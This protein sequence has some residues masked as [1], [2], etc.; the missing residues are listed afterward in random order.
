MRE[1]LTEL[2]KETVGLLEKANKDEFALTLFRLRNICTNCWHLGAYHKRKLNTD[3]CDYCGCGHYSPLF[4]T[5]KIK[6][7][8]FSGF[9]K[10]IDWPKT[11]GE[12]FS[13]SIT[14]DFGEAPM[15]P[16]AAPTS[17]TPTTTAERRMTFL[18]YCEDE[19]GMPIYRER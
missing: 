12:L 9:S 4:D 19:N 15:M 2:L 1:H 13:P 18:F 11:T 5:I 16:L 10:I 6:L 14:V 17:I 7:V 8:A 3:R